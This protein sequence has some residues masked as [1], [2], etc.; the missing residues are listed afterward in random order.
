[1]RFLS[2]N[3]RNACIREEAVSSNWGYRRDA[4]V[5]LITKEKPDVLALQE[6]SSEQLDYVRNALRES[7]SVCIDPAFYEADK[8]YN[9]ILVRKTLKVAGAGAFWICGN[10]QTQ[11]KIDGSICFRHATF[12]R[13]QATHA[14]L[15]VVNVH[16]DHT[17]NA[18]VKQT[19]M[20][21]FIDLLAGIGGVPPTR[22]IV[23]GDFNNVPKMEPHFLLEK[24]G[25]RDAAQ[26]QGSEDGTFSCWTKGSP[27]DRIDY[28]WLS[29]D[30]T[31]ALKTYRVILG[32]YPRQGGGLSYAS[33]HAA[34]LAQFDI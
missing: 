29:G 34:V 6:D 22:T 13:L 7:H 30:L 25:M 10:G 14:S 16:L 18:A 1:M 20:E 31:S 5:D 26:L 21:A 24:F 11:L 23:M 3:L 8:A 2:Y 19:E 4:V 9:A 28:I 33:D 32:A 17:E 12:V 15:L 27:S